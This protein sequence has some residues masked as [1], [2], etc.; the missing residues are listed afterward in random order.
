MAAE[1]DNRKLWRPE[2]KRDVVYLHVFPRENAKCLP[3]FSP[4]AMKLEM[5]LRL[6]DIPYVVIDHSGFSR[7]RQNPFILFNEEEIPDTNFIIEMLSAYFN[8]EIYP[9]ASSELRA[10]GRSFLKMVEENTAWTIYWYRYVHHLPEYMKYVKFHD[11]EEM[12]EKAGK[13]LG[14]YVKDRAWSHGIGRHSNEEIYKIGCDDVRAIST[15]LGP[16]IYFLGNTPTLVD[17]TLFAVLTQITCVPLDFPM[18]KV[19]R[20]E[21]PNLL[22]YIER[23]K[24]KCWPH[25]DDQKI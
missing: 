16:K 14:K 15:F 1:Q 11:D 10:V 5:W 18:M 20:E 13:D 17:C 21:C 23:L 25:W 12:N 7:K 4:Y 9:D 19:I 22:D 8:K 3:N 24:V 6:N 2:W